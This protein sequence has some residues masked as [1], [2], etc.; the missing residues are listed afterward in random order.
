MMKSLNTLPIGEVGIIQEI[1]CSLQIKRRLFDIGFIP[2]S[3][4]TPVYRGVF[5][6]PTAYFLR[7]ITIALRDSD[8]KH[9]LIK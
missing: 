2:G 9:I 8:A 1:N 4:V 7:G 3:T 5:G 6:N